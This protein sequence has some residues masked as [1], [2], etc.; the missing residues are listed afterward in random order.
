MINNYYHENNIA[1][2]EEKGYNIIRNIW[3]EVIYMEKNNIHIV[4]TE[5]APKA[6]GAY[7]Q[8]VKKGKFLFASGQIPLNPANNEMVAK[9]IEEQTKQSMDNIIGILSSTGMAVNNIL[10][11]TIYITDMT[12]FSQV[13]KVYESYFKDYYPARSCVEV[14]ALPKGALV[15]IEIIAHE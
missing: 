12:K 5:N 8:A 13:N 9:E 6:V 11:T 7:S 3:E 4:S 10:K 14:S 1:S 15:E 2:F